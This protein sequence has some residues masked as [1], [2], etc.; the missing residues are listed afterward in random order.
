MTKLNIELQSIAISRASQADPG[1]ARRLIVPVTSPETD[2]TIET[3][4][5]WELA[6]TTGADIKFIGLCADPMQEP[7]LRRA[8]VTMSAMM[9]YDNVA[10]ETEILPGRDIVGNLR[11]RLQPGDL[12]VC[13]DGQHAGLIHKPLSQILQ[14]ELDAPLY[15]LSGLSLENRSR[16]NWLT[17]AAAWIGSI[18]IIVGFF[19]LQVKVDHLAKDWT[20]VLQVLTTAVEFW[21]L[22]AWNTLLK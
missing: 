20:I 6:N 8:L 9:N 15:L 13:L 21:L 17:Q 2:L 4:R 22:W 11:S 12:I 1:P 5:V 19:M 10:A 16:S 18:A 7:S 14:S 3:Q